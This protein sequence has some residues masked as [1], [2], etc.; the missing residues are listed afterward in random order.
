[1]IKA[2]GNKLLSPTGKG[3]E[4]Y[5][6][7]SLPADEKAEATDTQSCRSITERIKAG[8]NT[9]LPGTYRATVEY[10]DGKCEFSITFPETE[11]LFTDIG[12]I[13]CVISTTSLQPPAQN[14]FLLKYKFYNA[15]D[16]E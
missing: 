13:Q 8:G 9:I 11:E 12:E 6:E 4:F 7:N 5:L 14:T 3:G 15:E 2:G 1:S 16:A 10:E